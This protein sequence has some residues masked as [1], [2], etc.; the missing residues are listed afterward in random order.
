M[1]TTT[2]YTDGSILHLHG[3]GGYAAVPLST[4]GTMDP[5][6]VICGS[7]ASNDIQEMELMAVVTAIRSVPKSHPVT[8]YTDHKTIC[9]VIARTVRAKCEKGRN[10]NIWNQLRQLCD[11]RDITLHWVRAHAGNQ[12]NQAADRAA[13]AAARSLVTK[14]AT[15]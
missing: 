3:C 12:G 5:S 9:D 15:C 14:M 2:F 11:S 10:R 6:K 7:K 13:R 8:I 4:D 1:E